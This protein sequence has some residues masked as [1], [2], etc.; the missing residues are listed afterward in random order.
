MRGTWAICKR[1]LLSYFVSPVAYIVMTGFVLLAG[2]FFCNLLNIFNFAMLQYSQM[3]YQMG[4]NAPSLNMEVIAPFYQTMMVVLIFLIPALT[5]KTIAEEK[6]TGTF[7]LLAISPISLTSIVVGKF[8]AVSV[9]MILM[10]GLSFLYPLYLAISHTIEIGPM[11]VGLLGLIL[12]SL[13]FISIGMAISAMTQNQVIA[14]I[15]GMVVLL[16]LYL[17]HAPAQN[18]GGWQGDV[19]SYL[20]PALNTV[21]MIKGVIETNRLIYFASLTGIGLFLSFRALEAQRW[22]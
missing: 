20:S 22:R 13:A 12:Y 7:E 8:L 1:E 9:V 14:A 15:S 3:P 18:M 10:L 2:Y 21:E 5:M 16:L 4:G 6:R 17:I 11:T 19:L